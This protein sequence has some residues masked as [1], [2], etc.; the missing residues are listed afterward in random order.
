MPEFKEED[1]QMAAAL[2]GDSP[3]RASI[4]Q[5][6]GLAVI[7]LPCLLYSMDLSVLFLALPAIS[8][9]LQPSSSELLWIVDIYGF[10]LAGFLIPMGNLGDRIGRRRLLM[11]G[12]GAFAFASVLAAFANGIAMLILARG[13]LGIAGATLAPSTLSLIRNMFLSDRERSLAVGIWMAS[14]SAGAALGPAVGGLMLTYF[15]WGS[16]FLLAVPIMI[17]LLIV[18]PFVLPEFRDP[19]PGPLDLYSAGLSIVA[20]LSVIFGVKQIAELGFHPDSLLAIFLG[21]F[22]G[23]AFI[24]RQKKLV[25]PFINLDLFRIAEFSAS[26]GSYIA[27]VFI[28]FSAFLFS[29]QCTQLVY[30][31]TP[32]ETG[33]WSLPLAVAL[34]VGSILAPLL[35]RKIKPGYVIGGSFVACA[36]GLL[37]VS[38]VG[39]VDGRA[40]L[41][42]GMVLLCLGGAPVGT[43]ATDLIVGSAP[44]DRAGAAS[45]ISETVGELGGALGIA[46]TGSIATAVYRHSMSLVDLSGLGDAAKSAGDTFG[47]AT[48]LARVLPEP[49][50]LKLLTASRHAFMNGFSISMVLCAALALVAAISVIYFLRKVKSE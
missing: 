29:A 37:I 15:W 28:T 24:Q 35:I 31:M 32:L 38:Q 3:V 50:K 42:S 40:M 34:G 16:V 8:A 27:Y 12:A 4:R 44:A 13:I 39:E 17:L 14:F 11:I 21:I 23:Y 33:L 41:L 9:D 46:I 2:N 45:A 20:V 43:L 49:A 22:I 5:W 47:Q 36:T 19:R 10:L 48:E 6:I 1:L 30:D 25:D 18:G 7:A 26:L